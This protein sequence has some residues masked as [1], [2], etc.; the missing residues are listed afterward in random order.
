[1]D[2]ELSLI[3]AVSRLLVGAGIGFCIGLTGVGGGVLMLPALTLL[4]GMDPVMAVGTASLYSFLTKASA[5]W[6][7]VRLKTID[8]KIAWRFLIGAVP[9]N[10]VVALWITS[11]GTDESFNQSLK[12]FIAGVICFSLFIMLVNSLIKRSGPAL[13]IGEHTLA[14]YLASHPAFLHGLNVVIGVMVGSLIGA[15]SIGGGVLIIPVLIIVFGL[16]ASRTVGTSIF[17]AV[18]LTLITASI[19]GGGKE[20]DVST[21]IVAAL[22][23]LMTVHYG[24]RLAVRLPDRL[25]KAIVLGLMLVTAVLMVADAMR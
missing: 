13:R 18:V 9:A 7:H 3:E 10:I 11:H 1:M 19:Y 22:G 14:H 25:L 15:T 20:V 16:S 5:T 2:F 8:W 24:S 17:I 12:A 6:H 21:V 23:S 4:F